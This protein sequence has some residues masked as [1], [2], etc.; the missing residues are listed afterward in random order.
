MN[1]V[2]KGAPHAYE[3]IVA[4]DEKAVVLHKIGSTKHPSYK[5]VVG[6]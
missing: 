6:R 4:Y 2:N 1:L 5:T 3:P